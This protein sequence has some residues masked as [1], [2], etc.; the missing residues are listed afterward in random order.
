MEPG[1][2]LTVDTSDNY[3][4][5]AKGLGTNLSIS[6]SDLAKSTQL[7][8]RTQDSIVPVHVLVKDGDNLK[9]ERRD[10]L[11]SSIRCI[12]NRSPIPPPS[13]S[14]PTPPPLIPELSS[15]YFHTAYTDGSW[16][17]SNT[18]ESLLLGNGTVKTAGAIVLHTNRG[19]LTIKVVMDIEVGGAFEAELVSLLIA[20][21][22]SN[23]RRIT[24]W[25]DCEAALKRLNGGGLGPLSQVLSG[26]KKS[27]NVNFCKVKAHPERRLPIQDWSDAEKGNFLADQVAG[28]IVLP[29]FTI[30]AS[31]WLSRIG[32]RS[33]IIIAASAGTPV[34]R[35]VS[36]LKS[37]IDI[38][39]YL[40]ERDLYRA[41][42]KRPPVWMDANI[43][44]HHALLGRSS[45]IGDRVITQRI[46]LIKRWQWFS[47]R[48]DNICQG[49]L[50]EITDI[51]H[52][53]RSCTSVPMILARDQLWKE[54]DLISSRAPRLLQE[55]LHWITR[56]LRENEG[57]EI[58]CCGS[59]RTDFTSALPC[60]NRSIS[61]SEVKH[62]TKLLKTVCAGTRRLLRL[63]AELQLGPLGINLRQT[64]VLEYLKPI[65]DSSIPKPKKVR[66]NYS[67]SPHSPNTDNKNNRNL[68]SSKSKNNIKQTIN[69]NISISDIFLTI[70][71]IHFVYWEFKAG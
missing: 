37:K 56:H 14:P 46:G 30:C 31:E 34:I 32:K 9:I 13:I 2:A 3:A 11:H 17:K 42:D 71:D 68:D 12:R 50:T 18:I 38:K 33:K 54:V 5:Y 1:V 69:R 10:T 64:S 24:I 39:E 59:F 55:D 43:A 19:M 66:R 36:S 27:K 15:T 16:S 57:G 48:N 29:S 58:A 62:L 26:W 4:K 40:A 20:H 35:E 22:L 45:K 49:C 44:M 21:E 52:P 47:A 8:E 41:K 61:E 53:L 25:T 63:A 65:A 6:Y 28:G 51:R 7:V 67:D 70:P 60:R 23:N